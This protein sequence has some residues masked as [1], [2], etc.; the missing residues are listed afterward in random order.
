M[1]RR[2]RPASSEFNDCKSMAESSGCNEKRDKCSASV[3]CAMHKYGNSVAD[4]FS[5]LSR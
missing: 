1:A 4:H 3:A 2:S 5:A